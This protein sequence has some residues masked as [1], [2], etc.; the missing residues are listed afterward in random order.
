[1]TKVLKIAAAIVFK[2][3]LLVMSV[4]FAA[5]AVAGVLLLP[6]DAERVAMLE[7]D[8]DN[9]RALELLE[10]HYRSGDRSQRTLY[11]LE[12]LYQHFG[13]LGQ[14][15]VMLEKL[16]E[17]RPRDLVLQ[18]R[19]VKFYRD[20]QDGDAYLFG[21]SRLVSQ[22]YSEP[23]C[24]E[25]IAQLRLTGQYARE[26][27]AIERCRMKG[28]RRGSDIVRLAELEQASG[29]TGRAIALLRNVDDI[30]GLKDPRRRLMLTSLLLDSGSTG[31]VAERSTRWIVHERDP[32]FADVLVSYLSGR[33]AHDTAIMI[34]SHA[35]KPGDSLSLSV[36]EMM[37]DRD[38]AGA[39][40]SYLRGWIE[41]SEI[42]EAQ[43]ASRFIA[44]AL[45]A[46][47]PEVALLAARRFGMQRL[48]ETDLVAIAEALGATGRRDEFEIV[49]TA[50]SA[51]TLVAHP[52][53]SAMVHLNSGSTSATREILDNTPSDALDT[54][55]L[56]LWTRLMRDTGNGALADARL[57]AL[58]VPQRTAAASDDLPTAAT[59]RR[60][61]SRT[62]K[63]YRSS[64]VR[65]RALKRNK[66]RRG[67]VA[68][69][70]KRGRVTT[71]SSRSKV[72]GRK[73]DP[74]QK[75]TA[76]PKP[77]SRPLALNEGG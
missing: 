6:G 8:G 43:L 66:A 68:S 55:R 16:A 49:R 21:L 1:M 75:Y 52:L 65:M 30:K 57:R 40:R 13:N 67:M 18:R 63:R 7:R 23:A 61:S 26:R 9:I 19:L 24:R 22:R 62:Y 46:Q 10:Q 71:R 51:D 74:Q 28:Y 48:P 35:G 25:L 15:R 58:G 32:R 20:T 70:N 59:T 53:L 72:K 39:A 69:A 54:W 36:A 5:A 31:E 47:D 34:A 37:L 27:E 60:S 12:Q 45:D 11:Q 50:L 29:N 73:V 4:I 41:N 76:R 77:V 44:A 2:P 38:Q 33:N 17:S 42:R 3:H 14:A 64:A 56:A